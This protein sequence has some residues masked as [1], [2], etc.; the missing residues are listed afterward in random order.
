MNF[1]DTRPSL[2]LQIRDPENHEAW[3]EFA[4]IYRPA[5]IRYAN[6]RGLQHADAEDLAQSVLV[7]VSKA[8]K[9][10]KPDSDRAKFRTWL[11]RITHHAVLNALTRAKPDLGS[12][13][14]KVMELLDSIPQNESES[15]LLVEIRREAF[16]YAAKQI[17]SEFQPETWTAFW[18]SAV[19]GR[20]VAE[21]AS[22][23]SKNSGSVYAARSRVMHRLREKINE[24]SFTGNF[25]EN[26]YVE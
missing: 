3:E 23:L 19:R 6:L 20:S 1:S 9:K 17:R 25:N 14:T 11:I 26:P 4:Q 22:H 2:L 15:E 12:G 18:E 8:I 5:I 13:N 10:W 16:R 7:S 21:I 24:I